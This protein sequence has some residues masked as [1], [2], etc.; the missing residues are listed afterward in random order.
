MTSRLPDSNASP[1]GDGHAAEK[2]VDLIV[3]TPYD[4]RLLGKTFHDLKHS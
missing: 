1:F 2:I 4:A 3:R